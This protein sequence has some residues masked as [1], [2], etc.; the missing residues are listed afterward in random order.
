MKN[1]WIEKEIIIEELNIRGF[2]DLIV[3]EDDGSIYLYDVKT[4]NAWSYKFKFSKKY[5]EENSNHHEMQLATYGVGVKKEFGRLDGMYIAYYNKDSSLIKE[6]EVSL[7][8]LT[9]VKSYWENRVEEH[10]KGVPILQE[11]VS[12][13]KMWECRYC[14]YKDKCDNETR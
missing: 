14:Q 4:M 12:P 1:V 9:Q 7:D 11:N 13:V 5:K 8:Y 2:A 10:K 3:E 6:K